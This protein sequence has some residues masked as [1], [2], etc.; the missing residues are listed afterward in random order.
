MFYSQEGFFKG[1]VGVLNRY[2]EKVLGNAIKVGTSIS[3]TNL[4]NIEFLPTG[5]RRL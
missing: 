4:L 2:K 5:N 1:M 3:M